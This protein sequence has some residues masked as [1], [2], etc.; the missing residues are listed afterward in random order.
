MSDPTWIS[1]LPPVM[2]I[3]L[4]IWTRQVYLSLAGGLWFA[5]TI[6]EGWNPLI[7]L[8]SS[9][10][11]ARAGCGEAG[12]ARALPALKKVGRLRNCGAG[13]ARQAVREMGGAMAAL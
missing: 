13:D 8:A 4:A 3:V 10:E 11:G 9:I 2:A 7:G 6:L 12:D 1:I 5:W